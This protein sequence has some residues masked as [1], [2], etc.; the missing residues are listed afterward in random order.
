MSIQARLTQQDGRLY[1]IY[2]DLAHNAQD[3]LRIAFQRL[4][5]QQ[6]PVLEEVL[7]REKVTDAQLSAAVE[8]MCRFVAGTQENLQVSYEDG[9]QSSGWF[10][11]QP[12]AQ[13]AV[14]AAI[15]TVLM[16][17]HYA[18]IRDATCGEEQPALTLRSLA[19][20]GD[21]VSRY[22]TASRWQRCYYRL[23]TWYRSLRR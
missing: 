1:N 5:Y 15:G 19:A 16:G 7:G 22:L 20:V 14:M 11:C 21:E 3:I 2:R 10:D 4:Q 8:A 9:L 6:W 13:V 17:Y 18:A 12:A 23:L